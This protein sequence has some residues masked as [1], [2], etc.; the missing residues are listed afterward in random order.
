MRRRG[1][2]KLLSA[3]ILLQLMI[4]P[5]VMYGDTLIL[6]NGSLLVGKVK[7]SSASSLV[8]KNYY[9][10]FNVK[11]ADV[12]RLYI[13]GTYREDVALRKKMGMDFSEEDIKRNY[14]AGEKKLTPVEENKLNSEGAEQKETAWTGGSILVEGGWFSSYGDVRDTLP[15]G[16]GGFIVYEQ[17][18]DFITGE[19]YMVMPG[20]RIEGG[21]LY[22]TKGEAS[23][24]G[25]TGSIGP[26]WKFPA[27]GGNVRFSMQPG[28]SNMDIQNGE[29]SASSFTFT[30][31]SILGYEYIFTDASIF[32][33]ARYLYI[34]DR[35]V[36]YN[37]AGITAGISYKIW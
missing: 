32:I 21:Y 28:A 7:S 25:F 37:G 1:T 11:R 5:Q 6:K 14:E 33:N 31:Y 13:T 35:D 20:I 16:Y 24:K 15:Y 8:F 3:A 29:L 9:G 22:F 12:A 2:N 27:P 26:V 17:G 4:I 19:R 36:F 23:M 10:A 30:F 34:Y 18:L